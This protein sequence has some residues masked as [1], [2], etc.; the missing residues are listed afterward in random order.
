M[1]SIEKTAY[2]R[3]T[4]KRLSKKELI[5]VYSPSSDDMHLAEMHTRDSKNKIN[6]LILF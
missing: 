2:P 4:N 6:F 3:F 1:A 5:Q